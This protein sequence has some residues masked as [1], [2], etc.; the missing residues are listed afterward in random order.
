MYLESK[1]REKSSKIN[2]NKAEYKCIEKEETA[3]IFG[4]LQENNMQ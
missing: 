3:L 2:F 1:V 4:K